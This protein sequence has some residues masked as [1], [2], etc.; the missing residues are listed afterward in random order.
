MF[1][2]SQIVPLS[3]GVYMNMYCTNLSLIVQIK[4][5][6]CVLFWPSRLFFLLCFL[7]LLL[8]AYHW[9]WCYN[10]FSFLWQISFVF[11][12][13]PLVAQQPPYPQTYVFIGVKVEVCI[14]QLICLKHYLQALY[15]I[16]QIQEKILWRPSTFIHILWIGY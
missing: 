5:G 7:F 1:N 4:I 2:C 6:T 10:F 11:R 14:L 8:P 9:T 15:E 13:Q 16:T 3:Y 12:L